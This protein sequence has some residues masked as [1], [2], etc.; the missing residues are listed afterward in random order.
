MPVSRQSS[1]FTL[2][3]GEANV[4]ASDGARSSR[5]GSPG[6]TYS[7]S[8]MT[9]CLRR[10]PSR[11]SW[12]MRIRQLPPEVWAVHPTAEDMLARHYYGDVRVTYRV[13]VRRGDGS[14]EVRRGHRGFNFAA[15]GV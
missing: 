1:S 13:I 12:A 5:S 14:I 9:R 7:C 6:S 2:P 8:A 4:A 10:R 3:A 15:I 11:R